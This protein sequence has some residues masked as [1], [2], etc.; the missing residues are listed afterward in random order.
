MNGRIFEYMICETL[1]W[2][3]L[4]PFYYQAKFSLVP[5]T[6][7]LILSFTM[8]DTLSFFLLKR[9]RERYKQ[10][11][12][13][14]LALKQVYR[15]AKQYLI[16]LNETEAQNTQKKIESGDISGIENIII[17]TNPEYDDLLNTLKKQYNFQEVKTIK[18][19]DGKLYIP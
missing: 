2:K 6:V 10:A 12:L 3:G 15:N 11:D 1:A 17:A 16:T 18:P 4:V 5:K 9:V 14:S 19:M 13:E 7:N 8:N